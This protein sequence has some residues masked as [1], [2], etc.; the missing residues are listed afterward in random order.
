MRLL[1]GDRRTWKVSGVTDLFGKMLN[2]FEKQYGFIYV[3]HKDN[4]KR[5]KKL[6]FY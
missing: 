2:G 1:S 4:L 3:D 6:S 5:K